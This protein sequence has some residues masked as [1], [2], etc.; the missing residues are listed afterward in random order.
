M[1]NGVSFVIHCDLT[2]LQE[3]RHLQRNESV[4]RFGGRDVVPPTFPSSPVPQRLLPAVCKT[5]F[6]A[7][8]ETFHCLLTQSGEFSADGLLLCW[9]GLLGFWRRPAH[10]LPEKNSVPFSCCGGDRPIYFQCWR[11]TLRSAEQQKPIRPS[12][13]RCRICT[14]KDAQK[15]LAGHQQQCDHQELVCF[16]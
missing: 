10:N 3:W 5:I 4:E 1:Y 7:Q 12:Y 2:Q 14:S 8:K 16:Y 9:A 15:I 13:T 6:G 11:I